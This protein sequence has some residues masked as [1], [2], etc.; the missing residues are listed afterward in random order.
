MHHEFDEGAQHRR[1]LAPAGAPWSRTDPVRARL[2]VNGMGA[3]RVAALAGLGAALLPS[4]MV[5]SDLVD[6]TA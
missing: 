2:T 1:H 3:L 4:R 6:R 5:A